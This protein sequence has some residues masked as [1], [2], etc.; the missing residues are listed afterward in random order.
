M[1]SFTQHAQTLGIIEIPFFSTRFNEFLSR[2]NIE[3]ASGLGRTVRRIFN[4]LPV[5][6]LFLMP[7]TSYI[8]LFKVIV[9]QSLKTENRSN[10]LILSKDL[11]LIL[12]TIPEKNWLETKLEESEGLVKKAV[13]S[14][15]VLSGSRRRLRH[16]S[17]APEA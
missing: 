14:R 13:K 11:A 5:E 9:E 4:S 16:A 12:T 17:G 8:S 15:L 3:Y 10:G 6:I 7:E 2:E 1:G